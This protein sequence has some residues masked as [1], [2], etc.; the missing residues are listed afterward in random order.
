MLPARWDFWRQ[1]DVWKDV[2][3]DIRRKRK[4]Y[5]LKHKRFSF[6]WLDAMNMNDFY[7][8]KCKND[9]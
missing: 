3:Q 7:T 5:S 8:C 4:Y 6:V 9:I 2:Y 1:D